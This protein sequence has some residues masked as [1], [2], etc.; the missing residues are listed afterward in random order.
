MLPMAV[1]VIEKCRL[2]RR[3]GTGR[4]SAASTQSNE[5]WKLPRD[6]W[7]QRFGPGGKEGALVVSRAGTNS[8]AWTLLP[9]TEQ[10]TRLGGQAPSRFRM[11]PQQ[12]LPSTLPDYCS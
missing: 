2:A 9:G 11:H 7:K 4:D 1:V 6:S 10:G 5:G 3:F 12:F 8:P